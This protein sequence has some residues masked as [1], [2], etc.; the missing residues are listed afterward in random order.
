MDTAIIDKMNN[1]EKLQTMEQ[2]WDVLCK[3]NTNTPSWHKDVIDNRLK[4]HKSGK[5]KYLSLDDV[6]NSLT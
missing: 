1:T 4:L 5:G 3:N 2:L 6:R